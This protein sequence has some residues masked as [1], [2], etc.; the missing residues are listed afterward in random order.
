VQTLSYN[1]KTG[2]FI[3]PAANSKAEDLARSVGLTKSTTAGVWYTHDEYAALA[4]RKF[5][6]DTA[7]PKLHKIGIEYDKSWAQESTKDYPAPPGM[8][9]HPFQR[10]GI[11]YALERRNTLIG[12]Q[13]GLGKTI[14]AIGIANALRA[15][16]VLVVCPA[17]VR[18]QWRKEIRL[19]ST[20]PRA[21]VY[22][23]LKG[24]DG[25]NPY[26]AY[27]IISYDL[28]RNELL[29]K[30]ICAQRWDLLIMDEG[31]YLKSVGALRTRALF[32]GGEGRFKN[33]GV[34]DHADRIVTLTGT[35]LPNRPK[36]CYTLA[37][38]LC[39]DAIDWQSQDAF[40]YKYNP[41]NMFEE[42]VGR[43]P[44]LRARLRCNLM[45][46]RMKRDV[47]PQLPPKTYELT[48]VDES[49]AIKDALK[50]ESML[51]IDPTALSGSNFAIE[52]EISTVRRMMGEAMAP[53]A[54]EH[55]RMLMD[56]GLDKVVVFGWHRSVLDVLEEGLSKYGLVRIDGRVSAV[57]KYR[58]VQDFRTDAN[59]RVFLG[60]LQASGTGTDGLQDV[61]SHAVF[62]EA[63]WVPG[64]NEQC[65][66]RL[67]RMGQNN[68]VLAQFL[69]ATGSFAERVLSTAIRKHH[70]THEALDGG[71]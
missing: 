33:G 10:A 21:H 7:A 52:G 63:S 46:R 45:V 66:D 68:G 55:V 25:F 8:E 30:E 40:D 38:S 43:L 26:A 24:S 70:T 22:P 49:K 59:I 34:A 32:G 14:Q 65:V 50:A 17:S 16:K 11:E 36:E 5:A 62:S 51:D 2:A 60:N 20:I 18:L 42:R 31:H 29:H 71:N 54:V 35:P 37:R 3:W 1:H 28:M 58:R 9:Y 41:S 39:W 61:C 48:Y 53:D 27:T 13:P 4:F 12:D 56:S 47:L 67:D 57:A 23:I 19:W 69:V 15:K 6:D 44:E 64:E